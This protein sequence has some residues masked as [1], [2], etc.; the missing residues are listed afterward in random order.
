MAAPTLVVFSENEAV[1]TNGGTIAAPSMSWQ[2]NDVVVVLAANEGNLASTFT[3]PT[4]TGTGL[5]FTNRQLHNTTAADPGG[6]GWTA[7]ATG[8]S[9]GTISVGQSGAGSQRIVIG[10]YIYRSS[11]GVGNSAI[12]TGSSRTV[13]LTAAGG[14]DGGMSWVSADWAAVAVVA[15][16]PTTTTHGSGA[17]GPTASPVSVQQSPSYTYYVGNLDDQTSAGAVAYGVGGSGTGPFTII[18]VEAKAGAG[19]PAKATASPIYNVPPVALHHST[20][21]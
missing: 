20:T 9:T 2:T 17:P 12:S 8:N 3:G 5:S 21:W 10:V 18:A 1:V 16:T 11:T 14:A 6:A 4:T 13:N 15:F 7:V 19:A